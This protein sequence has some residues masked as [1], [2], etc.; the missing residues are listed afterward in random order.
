MT[1]AK[2]KKAAPKR[3]MPKFTP[4]P[5]SLKARF[6]EIIARYPEAEPRKMF[7]YPCAFVSGQMFLGTFA[8]RVMMRLS[9]QDRAAFL[10]LPDAK[11]LEPMP[12]RPMREYV[13]VP[14]ELMESD[15]QLYKWID[16]SIAYAAALPP[17]KKS[18]K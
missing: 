13:Q 11:L 10:K 14:R 16:K 18:S 3:K 17:K 7:G 8:D 6:A 2:T 5:E 12:G 9:E 1:V 15:K 4:A